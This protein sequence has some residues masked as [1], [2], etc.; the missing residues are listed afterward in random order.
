MRYFGIGAAIEV[1]RVELLALGVLEEIG[2]QHVELL[3]RK[4]AVL[5]PP[6]GLLGLR[7]A[8]HELVLG[9]AAGVDAGL[10]AERA[11]LDDMTFPG[12]D[13]VF[14]ELL[15]GQIPVDA[16][17]ILQAEPVRAMR[18]VPKTRLFHARPPPTSAAA[19]ACLYNSAGPSRVRPGPIVA[20][21]VPAKQTDR[22]GA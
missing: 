10:G 16:G 7:V 2:E 22:A 4:L 14:V 1:L 18:T 9:R 6:D 19:P 3:R 17:Q 21:I 12:G 13:R 15:G 5:L 11:A 20:I 8:D